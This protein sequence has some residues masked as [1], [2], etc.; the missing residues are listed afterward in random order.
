MY[1]RGPNDHWIILKRL[2]VVTRNPYLESRR[3][4]V[5]SASANGECFKNVS[6]HESIWIAPHLHGSRQLEK[7]GP[8]PGGFWE[9]DTTVRE[10]IQKAKRTLKFLVLSYAQ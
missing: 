4:G 2:F 10:M 8:Y 6:S 9:I 3:D 1:R 7:V 5:Y